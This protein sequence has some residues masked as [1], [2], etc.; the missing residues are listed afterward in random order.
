[1]QLAEN[2]WMSE[3]FKLVFMAISLWCGLWLWLLWKRSSKLTL[4]KTFVIL[5]GCAVIASQVPSRH[6]SR[7]DWLPDNDWAPWISLAC[8]LSV[9]ALATFVV[10]RWTGKE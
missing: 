10:M 6:R 5:T 4:R 1:M 8:I 2:G 7:W 9:W 3:D